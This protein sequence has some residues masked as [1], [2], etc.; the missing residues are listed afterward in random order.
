MIPGLPVERR[1][2][3]PVAIAAEP[4]RL[5]RR[6]LGFLVGVPPV[7]YLL[8]RLGGEPPHYLA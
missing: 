3:R 5:R 2:R 4:V 1:V 8:V 7:L 6:G